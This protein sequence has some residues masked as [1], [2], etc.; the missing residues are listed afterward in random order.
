MIATLG[1]SMKSARDAIA[2]LYGLQTRGMKF[3]LHGIQMLLDAVGNPERQIESIHIAGS[4]GKG[5]TAAFIAAAVQSA[6]Y[7]TGLYTSPH[8]VRFNERIRINGIPISDERILD[9]VRSL[10]TAIERHRTTFF[11]AV[12]AITFRY[13]ADEDVECAVIETGLGG[14]LDATNVL[15]PRVSVITE[16]SLEHTQLLGNTLA[17]IAYEKAGVIKH[18]VPCVSGVRTPAARNVI[19]RVCRQRQSRLIEVS[20]GRVSLLRSDIGGLEA[21]FELCGRKLDRVK[22]GLPGSHQARNAF[23]ALGVLWELMDQG[24]RLGEENIRRGLARVAAMTGLRGR[25]TVVRRRPMVIMDVAHN[26]AAIARLTRSLRELGL[27]DLTV[28]FGVMK[29]KAFRRMIGML[30]GITRRAIAVQASTERARPAREIAEVFRLRGVKAAS[31]GTVREGMRRARER[32]GKG[33]V[34]VT[35]SHFVV[36]EALA[37]LERKNYLTINQ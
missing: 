13:F 32:A 29:D 36:G 12:T 26:P 22:I 6:G 11:E 4:N 5:S 24:F 15:I 17:E 3:G 30:A 9:Y 18:H 10:R 16:I 28:V 8:L 19:R 23:V 33:A 20:G 31:A 1:L 2:Y 34:L 14:R 7:R 21:S 35:G 37:F 27:K 25:M